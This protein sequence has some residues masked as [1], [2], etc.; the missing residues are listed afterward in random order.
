MGWKPPRGASK[1]FLLFFLEVAAL[2]DPREVAIMPWNPDK[3]VSAQSFQLLS[4]DL[5]GTSIAMLHNL[6]QI[7]HA[8]RHGLN[9]SRE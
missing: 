3:A 1:H 4:D 5:G 7:P 2:V 6:A 9:C 8:G